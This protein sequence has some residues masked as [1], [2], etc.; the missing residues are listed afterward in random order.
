MAN[1]FEADLPSV[2]IGVAADIITGANQTLTGRVDYIAALVDP[3]TRAVSVRIDVP[4]PGEVLKRDLYVHVRLHSSAPAQGILVPVS[5][6]LRDDENLPF[7]F[8]AKPDGT[9]ER[10]RID[11]GSRSGDQQ[12]VR[13][14]LNPG[15]WI[16]V[17]GG[18]F[19][20]NEEHS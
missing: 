8:V 1:V 19:L 13:S 11:L 2:H 18:L 15:E 10:R 5:A 16:V 17:E 6:I 3:N 4:N 7:V 14:G 20:Q 12:E 9:Y